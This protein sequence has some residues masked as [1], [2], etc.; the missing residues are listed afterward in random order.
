[1]TNNEHIHVV[2]RG[3]DWVGV[4]LDAI[5]ITA[6]LISLGAGGRIVN[7][8]Q[9]GKAVSAAGQTIDSAS[10][11]RSC[12][13]L[14]VNLAEGD[15]TFS[16]AADFGLDLWGLYTPILPDAISLTV[17]LAQGIYIGP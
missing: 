3:V 7:G 2:D 14:A 10:L 12:V 4:G 17:G 1:M 8:I 13:P 5:G 11:L 9:V 16:Q 6:D 15:V